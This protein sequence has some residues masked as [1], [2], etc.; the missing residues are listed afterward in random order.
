M[1]EGWST[2]S[3][4]EL[5]SMTWTSVTPGFPTPTGQLSDWHSSTVTGQSP[6]IS[7]PPSD[8]NQLSTSSSLMDSSLPLTPSPTGDNSPAET[9]A[10]PFAIRSSRSLNV[11]AIAVG[12]TG[13]ALFLI[14]CAVI[15]FVLWKRK[16]RNKVPP[17]AEFTDV[18]GSW[19][20]ESYH[21]TTD[22]IRSSVFTSK[23]RTSL[24]PSYNIPVPHYSLHP[25]TQSAQP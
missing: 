20:T 8:P 14:A 12:V 16:Q 24:T 10:G 1:V 7:P 23:D 13:A 22:S 25:N 3:S 17:S 19:H 11:A 5:P 2:I 15:A 18:A 9:S 21:K 4:S 6:S